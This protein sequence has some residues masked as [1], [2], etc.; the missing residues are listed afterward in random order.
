MVIMGAMKKLGV[1]IFKG[2][3]GLYRLLLIW[4]Q[5]LTLSEPNSF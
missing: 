3:T 2:V 4:V 1:N 5:N